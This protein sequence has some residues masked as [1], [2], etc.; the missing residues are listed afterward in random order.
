MKRIA[1]ASLLL[2][3]FGCGEPKAPPPGAPTE[4]MET[5]DIQI[6]TDSDASNTDASNPAAPTENKGA[7]TGTSAEQDSADGEPQE[8]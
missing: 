4:K 1:L 8:K 6:P 5:P 7:P 2:T 3:A